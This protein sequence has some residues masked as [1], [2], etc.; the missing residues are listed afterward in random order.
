[1][2]IQYFWHDVVLGLLFIFGV[3]GLRFNQW[4]SR[5]KTLYSGPP[6]EYTHFSRFSAF[7]LIYSCS[8]SI[9]AFF[10]SSMGTILFQFLESYAVDFYSAVPLLHGIRL[11]FGDSSIL[12][13]AII[14]F[15][16]LKI[17]SAETYEI[18]WRTFLQRAARI[19][20]AVYEKI[21]VLKTTPNSFTP[22]EKDIAP[23]LA[24]LKE[25][26]ILLDRVAP[27]D[28]A[29][30]GGEE[31][32][33]Q[34]LY[35][36]IVYLLMRIQAE[37]PDKPKGLAN[38]LQ[39]LDDKNRRLSEIGLSL[40]AGNLD[41]L[42]EK[43]YGDELYTLQDIIYECIAR[44]TI[45]R[46]AS[47]ESQRRSFLRYNLKLP[48][49]DTRPK[50][51]GVL[52][53]MLAGIVG[54][55]LFLTISYEVIVKLFGIS[56]LERVS[57]GSFMAILSWVKS[58]AVL[59]FSAILTGIMTEKMFEEDQYEISARA[60]VWSFTVS[61][62]IAFIYLVSLTGQLSPQFYLY[63]LS[64][65]TA[66]TLVVWN[67][68]N[69][70]YFI[71]GKGRWQAPL[72]TATHQAAILGS[73][74]LVIC[75][76]RSILFPGSSLTFAEAVGFTLFGGVMGG[77]MGFIIGFI[78]AHEIRAQ[79]VCRNRRSPRA[80]YI[81]QVQAEV[82]PKNIY[83]ATEN[84]SMSGLML[85]T[86]DDIDIGQH[87]TLRLSFASLVGRVVWRTGSRLGVCFEHTEQSLQPVE[88]FI[89]R[90]FGPQMLYR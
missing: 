67:L 16:I 54:L 6:K 88:N 40:S 52:W 7:Y 33:V 21:A 75:L 73:V 58:S 70:Q 2:D 74:T 63:S 11:Q 77:S 79:L 14:V 82:G 30:G 55:S 60:Y 9:V 49:K 8:I 76:G 64:P 28:F 36:K 45:I 59:Y 89:R 3:I 84:I 86:D 39:N 47:E 24:E 50:L 78:F 69:T 32:S 87:I 22:Q 12:A 43:S 56:Q 27:G 81:E 48:Y 23:V 31:Q 41:A 44:M 37:A 53:L 65:A 15:L 85:T 4:P 34:H 51:E 80:K 17:P 20:Q 66:S 25:K 26:N 42:A 61:Y 90:Q 5:E 1:M 29:N 19:P 10:L 18:R 13:S 72:R 35:V 57:P 83:A 71:I 46:C 62:L 38:F 68:L